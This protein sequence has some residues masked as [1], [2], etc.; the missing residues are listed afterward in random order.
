[1][2]PQ[3]N[4][5]GV[6]AGSYNRMTD[7]YEAT[8]NNNNNNASNT[9][10]HENLHLLQDDQAPTNP[11]VLRPPPH[12]EDWQQ[13][14]YESWPSL[15]EEYYGSTVPSST[16]Y[17]PPSTPS[18]EGHD[19]D[20]LRRWIGHGQPV[21]DHASSHVAPALDL[22]TLA[23][24][25]NFEKVDD[26]I[27]LDR[28]RAARHDL[29]IADTMAVSESCDTGNLLSQQLLPSPRSARHY[30]SSNEQ[31]W[32]RSV[33]QQLQPQG[34]GLCFEGDQADTPLN[35]PPPG[36]TS[37]S[38]DMSSS[39]DPI[40]G[41]ATLP[42]TQQPIPSY[43]EPS[44][45]HDGVTPLDEKTLKKRARFDQ[46]AKVARERR[47]LEQLKKASTQ[48]NSSAAAGH[49]RKAE[50]HLSDGVPPTAP[51]P[52][53]SSQAPVSQNAQAHPP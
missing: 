22:N 41:Y 18:E 21:Q 50:F 35:M 4:S 45:G 24:Y 17:N 46:N 38:L 19:I 48:P 10:S 30:Q 1:M 27:Q 7:S 2:N 23:T 33:H 29:A 49:K 20:F 53:R 5:F 11:H 36:N 52:L 6:A 12:V 25:N 51:P 39:D 47:L 40:Q 31:A 3:H 34:G 16:E 42:P 9:V 15:L 14:V 43:L 44:P 28:L 8:N 26:P 37:S 13:E 32:D